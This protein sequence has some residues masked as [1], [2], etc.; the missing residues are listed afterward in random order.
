M[1]V[2]FEKDELRFRLSQNEAG[3]LAANSPISLEMELPQNSFRKFTVKVDPS[4]TS[5]ML[6]IQNHDMA[7]V[8]TPDQLHALKEAK[9]KKP[10]I[11]FM[12]NQTLQ[13]IVEVDAFSD[14]KR[15]NNRGKY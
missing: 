11:S 13:I 12:Q 1:N 2:R 8:I 5:A 14:E 6:S 7:C 3:F 9:G 10:G 15:M 4:L